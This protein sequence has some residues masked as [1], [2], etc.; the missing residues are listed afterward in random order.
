MLKEMNWKSDDA[1]VRRVVA[2]VMDRLIDTQ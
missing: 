2:V 1:R